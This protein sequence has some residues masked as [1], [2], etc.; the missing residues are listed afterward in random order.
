MKR[1]FAALTPLLVISLFS[2][3]AVAQQTNQPPPYDDFKATKFPEDNLDNRSYRRSPP[4]LAPEDRVIT[5]GPLAA[6][7]EDRQA[8]KAFLREKNTGLMRLLPRETSHSS[9]Q[10]AKERQ[11]KITGGGAYYSFALLTHL[12]GYGSDIELQQDKLSVGFAGADYGLLFQLGDQPLEQ[13]TLE[14]LRVNSL[15]SYAPPQREAE[16][17]QEYQRLNSKE[18]LVF[19]TQL[20]RR[21]LP[22]EENMTYLLRSIS[23]SHSDVLVAFRVIRKD[24]DGSVV[25]AWKL[26]KRFSPIKLI[27]SDRDGDRPW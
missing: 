11:V 15:A 27:P 8:L 16:A 26:L 23:Y 2:L 5:E 20:Y 22:A 10:P 9:P 1:F 18:G 3:S 25:I 14:D 24:D 19:E 13:I 17:R 4:W 6:A 7:K 12:Y 21:S